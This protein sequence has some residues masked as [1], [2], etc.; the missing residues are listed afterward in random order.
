MITEKDKREAEELVAAC[1]DEHYEKA[2]A[3]KKPVTLIGV[4]IA[5]YDGIPKINPITKLCDKCAHDRVRH[6]ESRIDDAVVE[7]EKARY[8]STVHLI[9]GSID[10]ALEALK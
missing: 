8:Y 7:L 5:C 1:A 3:N 10:R 2:E 9:V 6:L 4:C